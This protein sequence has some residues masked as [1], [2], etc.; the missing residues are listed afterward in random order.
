MAT[1]IGG[2]EQVLM[3]S[4]MDAAALLE[5][6]YVK[7]WPQLTRLCGPGAS[8]ATSPCHGPVTVDRRTISGS[9]GKAARRTLAATAK[10]AMSPEDASYMPDA[11]DAADLAADGAQHPDPPPDFALEPDSP[12]K[13]PA[14]RRPSNA[15]TSTSWPTPHLTSESALDCVENIISG[16]AFTLMTFRRQAMNGS[17]NPTP[18]SSFGYGSRRSEHPHSADFLFCAVESPMPRI[19]TQ[20]EPLDMALAASTASS[21]H[22]GR[23]ASLLVQTGTGPPRLQL[24]RVSWFPT[25]L[26]SSAAPIT[27]PSA[28]S[29]LPR[30]RSDSVWSIGGAPKAQYTTAA[31]IGDEEFDGTSSVN[32][33][34]LLRTL[35]CGAQGEVM[36]AMDTNVNEL[37]A[38]KVV[39]RPDSHASFD[40]TTPRPRNVR[41]G[42]EC[43]G[44]DNLVSSIKSRLHH[45]RSK[46]GQLQREIAAMKRCRHRNIVSLYEVIDDPAVSSLYLVMQYVEHGSLVRMSRD[47]TPSRTIQPDKLARYARQ[48]CAGLQYLH[49]HNIVHRDIKPDNILLGA[50]DVVYLSDFG[51]AEVFDAGDRELVSGTRG[52]VLFMSPEIV[53]ASCT[54]PKQAAITTTAPTPFTLPSPPSPS[55][56]SRAHVDGK[57]S[58][59]WALGL[60][61]YVLLYGRVAWGAHTHNAPAFD[62]ILDH[63][64][65]F[66]RA[67]TMIY[68]DGD[69]GR[70]DDDVFENHEVPIEAEWIA[71]LQGMLERDVCRRMPLA[72]VRKII[73][74]LADAAEARELEASAF[75][76]PELSSPQFT[77]VTQISGYGREVLR[78]AREAHQ[79]S[80]VSPACTPD[81]ADMNE[82][83][84]SRI[85]QTP[86]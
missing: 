30:G 72:S 85:A 42:E 75:I 70:S 40:P 6:L 59:V 50:D 36:L 55:A 9:F 74:E 19:P 80:D 69:G 20:P 10:G 49:N 7:V 86:E 51:V 18:K 81:A 14:L 39:A 61:F 77:P 37:R 62:S 82:R 76:S 32:Q 28:P 83:E 53:R 78:Q 38:I 73:H 22:G 41:P 8:L 68:D 25:D 29:R 48:L 17:D 24:R 13:P 52:T 45:S 57:L 27:P 11:A 43:P 35:G 12:G 84:A 47:G 15:A 58:D 63:V 64:I 54:T 4:P 5:Q 16:L 1:A 21:P 2:A 33:Y 31:M 23:R 66:P 79:A 67:A 65:D 44:S 71:L 26:I 34:V 3:T 60:T 46:I 56:E